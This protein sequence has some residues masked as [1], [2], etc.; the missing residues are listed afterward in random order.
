MQG[1]A[2]SAGLPPSENS[3]GFGRS[4]IPRVQIELEWARWYIPVEVC[5]LFQRR[6]Q[7]PVQMINWGHP[8][9]RGKNSYRGQNHQFRIYLQYFKSLNFRL[10]F[11]KD[12]LNNLTSWKE[13]LTKQVVDFKKQL[14]DLNQKFSDTQNTMLGKVEEYNKSIGDVNVEIKA[15]GKVFQKLIPEF[16]ENV[17]K[18]SKSVNKK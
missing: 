9:V 7:I 13:D 16:T 8:N 14:D 17:N 1:I 15:M 5:R 6:L 10:K 12:E 2:D 11:K 4:G 3:S 18:L